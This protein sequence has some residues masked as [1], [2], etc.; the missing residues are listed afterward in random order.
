M[1][2][3]NIDEL[4]SE[5]R[6][7]LKQYL[8]SHGIK[9][10]GSHFKCPNHRV[11]KSG[12]STPSAAFWP[13]PNNWNCLVCSAAGDI[14]HA[15]FYLENKPLQGYEFILDNVLY[16][17]NKFSIPY[18]IVEETKEEKHKKE[19]YDFLELITKYSCVYLRKNMTRKVVD[20]VE[21]RGWKNAFEPFLFGYTTSK[22]LHDFMRSKNIDDS[23]FEAAGIDLIKK[24]DSV[25]I[26]LIENR[27][28]IPW[29]NRFGK[30]SSFVARALDDDTKPKYLFPKTCIVHKKS[31]EFFNLREARKH[32][33]SLYVV[34][35]NASV[36]TLYSNGIKN[37]IALSGKDMSQ[38]Q[39]DLL[40]RS[41][42]KQITL[43][44]DN[45]SAGLEGMYKIVE[46][47]KEKSDL[48][49]LI[50]ELPKVGEDLDKKLKDPDDF[51]KKYGVDKFHNL[52]DIDA[53]SWIL[54]KVVTSEEVD[55]DDRNKDIL[56]SFI[57]K[58][59][60]FLKREKLIKKFCDKTNYTQKTVISEL[61]NISKDTTII[62]TR[63]IIDSK[64]SLLNDIEEFEEKVWSRTDDFLGFHTGW[65]EF[66]RIIDG[67]QEGF[68]VIAGRTNIGKSAFCLSLARNVL[69][70]NIDKVYGLYFNVDDNKFKC[71]GR[72]ISMECGLPI[73]WIKNPKFKIKLNDDLSEAEKEALLQRRDAAISLVKSYTK[74]FAFKSVNKVEDI[75]N[76]IKVYAKIAEND[77]KKLVVFIDKVHNLETHKNMQKREKIDFIS[78]SL[79]NCVNDLSIPLIGSLEVTKSS[80]ME[81]PTESDI[82]ETQKLEDDSDVCFLLYNDQKIDSSSVFVFKENGI[83]YPIVE[84]IVPK[85]KLNDLSGYDVRIFFK[86]YPHLSLFAECS[87][88][89]IESY[90]AIK[91]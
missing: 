78:V 25:Y 3:K 84:L 81:R 51:I 20:Y 32:S 75:C 39:Y 85:N 36:L 59:K 43:C 37:C 11:H 46:D 87:R 71:I 74:S 69:K 65:P 17:A 82:K 12:D 48:N 4:K 13:T 6:P 57:L 68:Y 34:E 28:L 45:D 63:E 9:T 40:I 27:L 7:F 61:E 33:D 73:N 30:V 83:E 19:V 5:I 76:I 14:F 54:N 91:S 18:E 79:K 31:T 49:I 44:L 47:F 16:L 56:F 24:G 72:M 60:N 42:V 29:K 26:P 23:M 21:Q 86:F 80:I 1:K 22:C 53:F 10:A 88:E 58:E 90:R 67:L 77:K 35:S 15:A 52:P 38:D 50:K 2:V 89:E 62:T 66:D 41:N 70:N 8:E 55:I 64:E